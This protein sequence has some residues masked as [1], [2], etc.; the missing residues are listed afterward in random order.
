MQDVTHKHHLNNKAEVDY[1]NTR[2]QNMT[3]L[4]FNSALIHVS[5]AEITF[6]LGFNLN[7]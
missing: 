5:A 2:T 7:R 1:V 6:H 4:P 3:F